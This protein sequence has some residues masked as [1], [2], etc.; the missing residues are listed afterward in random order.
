MTDSPAPAAASGPGPTR[1]GLLAGAAGA[2]A[3]ALPATGAAAG[4]ATASSRRTGAP[5]ARGGGRT[6]AVFGGGVGGL[7]AAHELAERGFDVTVY[8]RGG[9]GGK[10][11]SMPVPGTGTGGRAD[12]PGEHGFRFF[13]NAYRHLPDT[14]G[15]IPFP[16][17]PGGVLDNLTAATAMAF[18]R[19]HARRDLVV[20]LREAARPGALTPDLLVRALTGFAAQALRLPPHE[21]AFFANRVTVFLTSGNARRFGQWENTSWWEYTR[22]EEMSADYRALFTIGLTRN[23]TAMKAEIAGTNTLGW[24]YEAF[25]YGLLGIGYEGPFNRVLDAPTNEAWIDPW[26]RHLSSLGTRLRLGRTLER[27]NYAQGHIASATVCEPDGTRATVTADWYVLAVPAERAARLLNSAILAADP[28]LSGVARLRTEWMAGLQFYL[29]TRA[30]GIH[31]HVLHV[32][33]PWA[34]SSVGHAQFWHGRDFPRRYGDGSVE[35]CLSVSIADWHRPGVVYGRPALQCTAAEV[36]RETWSQLRDSL[37]VALPDSALHSWHLDPAIT[38][39]GTPSPANES[40]MLTFP[41]GSWRHRPE[42]AT[43]VPNLFL[44]ADYVRNGITSMEGAN[45]AARTAVNALLAESGSPAEPCRLWPLYEPPELAPLK[46][47]DDARHRLG[48]PHA[49]DLPQGRSARAGT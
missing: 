31:G 44:A 37:D 22:A 17:N 47:R 18:G 45:E 10:A 30:P 20:P 14:L 16:G 32:D 23:I 15:R 21:A 1:R 25:V 49:L 9:W 6:V 38:G 12:L 39:L 46:A 34:L 29:R 11:R 28:R 33:T 41:T 35:D 26:L 19:S 27:L 2:V 48:L 7:T 13:P 24:V 5:A 8:E 3:L 42:A 40:P 43:A 36:A 4:V